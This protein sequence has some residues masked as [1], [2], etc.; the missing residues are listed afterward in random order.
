M[1]VILQFSVSDKVD[2]HI[3]TEFSIPKLLASYEK[4]LFRHRSISLDVR[5]VFLIILQKGHTSDQTVEIYLYSSF[6]E[7]LQQDF[8]TETNTNVRRNL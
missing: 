5:V 3:E 8:A 1:S 4:A 7:V 2:T 6:E